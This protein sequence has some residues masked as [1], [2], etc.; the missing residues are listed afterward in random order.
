[1]PSCGPSSPFNLARSDLL[2]THFKGTSLLDFAHVQYLGITISLS[3]STWRALTPRTTGLHTNLLQ[4]TGGIVHHSLVFPCLKKHLP[5]ANTDNRSKIS[6][7]NKS[8]LCFTRE[9]A[10]PLVC[11]F[12]LVFTSSFFLYLLTSL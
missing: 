8:T 2:W 4:C 1:M 6:K 7:I 5:L 9:N 12:G 3:C 10:L 11:T